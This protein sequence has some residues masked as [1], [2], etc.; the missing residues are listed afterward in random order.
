MDAR[1]E[2]LARNEA[3]FRSVNERVEEINAGFNAIAGDGEFIC[4]CADTACIERIS[5]GLDDYERVRSQPTHFLIKPGH[6][7]EEIE[8]VVEHH[9]DF[10]VVA[11]RYD[12]VE[13]RAGGPAEIAE[14]TDP[15]S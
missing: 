13:A 6:A 4:E 15:R 5:M 10:E 12:V 14:E 1:Q 3:L 8:E 9:R 2:R 7:M 11:K